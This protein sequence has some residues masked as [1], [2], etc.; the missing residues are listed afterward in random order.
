MSIV[1]QGPQPPMTTRKRVH[2]RRSAPCCGV[3]VLDDLVDKIPSS[4]TVIVCAMPVECYFM[5][6]SH[7][8]VFPL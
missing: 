3:A 8:P 5:M 2:R 6:E 1:Y 4:V 7:C